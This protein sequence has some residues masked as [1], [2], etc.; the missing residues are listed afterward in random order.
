MVRWTQ[1]Y[2]QEWTQYDV[3]FDE[4]SIV[5]WVH[6]DEK[7]EPIGRTLSDLE[8]SSQYEPFRGTTMAASCARI[9]IGSRQA[10]ECA[11]IVSQLF[12][13]RTWLSAIV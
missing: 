8:S 7:L 10:S 2:S 6:T 9:S 11:R 13:V 3:R 12:L 5:G 1:I 4:N